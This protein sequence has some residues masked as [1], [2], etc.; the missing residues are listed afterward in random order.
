M[1][2]DARAVPNATIRKITWRI[3]PLP[4]VLGLVSIIDRTNISYAA[5]EMNKDLG[6]STTVYGLGAGILFLGYF[7]FEVPSNLL[8]ER[9]GARRWLARIAVTWGIIAAAM[10]LVH[11]ETVFYILRFLLGVAEAGLFP[12]VVLYLTYWFPARYRARA[13][14]LF[15]LS[16]PIASV[17][18]APMS[19]WLVGLDDVLGMSGWQFMFVVQGVP[20]ILLGV[21]LWRLLIDRPADASWLEPAERDWLN[22]ELAAEADRAAPSHRMSTGLRSGKVW[23]FTAVY[24][25]YA[26]GQ[27]GLI[28][29][30]PQIIKRMDFTNTQVG[31]IGT[32]PYIVG[33]IAMVVITRS[34]DRTGERRW[35]FAGSMLVASAGLVGA[36]LTMS[37]PVVALM[38]LVIVGIGAFGALGTFWPLPTTMLTGTA[39]AAGIAVIN[40]VGNTGGFV[41]PYAV[42]Y[43]TDHLGGFLPGLLLLAAFAAAGGVTYVLISRRGSTV[44]P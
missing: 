19:G 30:L 18:G 29:F 25:C 44:G 26:I 43:L 6:F 1:A 16:V 28:F 42:G 34:S 31:F 12:G 7:L 3:M 37:V 33:A 17:I 2:L 38:F 39:A 22:G 8:L 36:A 21:L 24:F 35:H 4:F 5:L 9:I 32:L 13:T 14:G 15:M 40:S 41:G 20:A 11:N 23:A 10:A 27:Y